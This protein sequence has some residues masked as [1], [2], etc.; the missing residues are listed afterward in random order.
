MIEIEIESTHTL[1]SVKYL[2]ISRAYEVGI[3]YNKL[4]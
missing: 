1:S 4:L 2:W 3:A